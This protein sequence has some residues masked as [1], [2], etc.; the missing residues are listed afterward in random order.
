VQSV[1]A[2]CLTFSSCMGLACGMAQGTGKSS[3]KGQR[4]AGKDASKDGSKE[5]ALASDVL[6]IKLT[7]VMKA[8]SYD[9]KFKPDQTVAHV[10]AKACELTH[11]NPEDIRIVMRGREQSDT[12][13]VSS[14]KAVRGTIKLM[15]MEK[16]KPRVFTEEETNAAANSARSAVD[17]A[18][19]E[20]ASCSAKVQH[21]HTLR[22][23]VLH[24]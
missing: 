17:A 24:S 2:S 19:G 16:P 6:A 8:K 11:K 12:T 18:C 5:N 9:L 1:K 4:Q 13:P 7:D 10:R 21:Q 14:L 20:L 23:L 15:M 22:V 3:T